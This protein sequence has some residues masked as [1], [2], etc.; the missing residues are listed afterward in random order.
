MAL[1]GGL[2]LGVSV[3]LSVLVRWPQPVIA[4]EFSYL[5]AADTFGAGRLANP[6]HPFWP[7]FESLHILQQPVYASKYQPAPGLLLAASQRL[8][9]TPVVGVWVV[10]ALGAVAVYWMLRAW[11]SNR[12]AL[13][14][15]LL[16]ALHPLVLE[17]GQNFWGG[18][19][20]LLGG[21]LT[22]GATGRIWRRPGRWDGLNLGLGLAILATS[23]PF[24]GAV[25]GLLC[26]GL[27]LYAGL[28]RQFDL[29]LR[30]MMRLAFLALL[31]LGPVGL[32][33]AS[34]NR[35]LTGSSLRMPYLVHQQSYAIA[36]PFLWQGLQTTP[37]YRHDSIRRFYLEYELA[38]WRE[39]QTWPGLIRKG[40][41]RKI[42]ILI[43]GYLATGT[44]AIAL[45]LFP[46]VW[47]RRPD[48]RPLWILLGLFISGVLTE[49]WLLPHYIA[50]AAGL[51]FLL[52][53][54]S[55]RI[56]RT[57]SPG[58]RRVGL[59]LAR[60]SLI[61]SLLGVINLA[62]R[63]D[64][65]E[66]GSWAWINDRTNLASRLTADGTRHLMLVRYGPAHNL[67][68]EW[69]YNA[70]DIDA[71]PVVWAREM[72]PESN[73]RLLDYFKDR[74]CHLVVIEGG[75]PMVQPCQP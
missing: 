57:W 7:H 32:S 59:W 52:A 58:G 28:H 54:D 9:S 56:L 60:A 17:W 69:V 71:A 36:T 51:L 15:G 73:R 30:G 23:R 24:E 68:Q 75:P 41:I 74:A 6:V 55:W 18:G 22:L 12:L 43:R 45:L 21:A 46:L 39:L 29:S 64:R 10:V 31:V 14:G 20:P 13:L 42:G 49:T 48:R 53:V 62:L 61:L 8:T 1:V 44:M 16:A 19:L 67:H 70:A 11:L 50:P 5:L 2:S 63:I 37:V 66:K 40:L 27:I 72:D 38:T 34:Y 26:G 4:D 35:H 25:L 3:T 33:I 47:R 65:D